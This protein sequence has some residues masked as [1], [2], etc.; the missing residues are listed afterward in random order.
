MMHWFDALMWGWV[1]FYADVL[2]LVG[3]IGLFACVV[4]GVIAVGDAAERRMR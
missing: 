3:L 1:H 2:T 4:R